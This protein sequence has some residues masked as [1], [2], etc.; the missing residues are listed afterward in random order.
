MRNVYEDMVDM[1]VLKSEMERAL[2]EYN[3]T[4]GVVPMRLVLF[5]DA[6]E[7]SEC[8]EEAGQL[9][10]PPSGLT[11]DRPL[12]P[13]SRGAARRGR[14]SSDGIELCPGL[15]AGRWGGKGPWGCL[16][17]KGTGVGWPLPQ[18]SL[19]WLVGLFVPA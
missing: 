17:K 5:R 11:W 8:R 4:P 16:V 12:L 15:S 18:G 2:G 14:G 3:R 9:Q 6:I 19:L 13:C 1:A 7:H 10:A